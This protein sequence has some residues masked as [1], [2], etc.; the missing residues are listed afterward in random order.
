LSE[1]SSSDFESAN[2]DD[3]MTEEAAT[4]PVMAADVLTNARRFNLESMN[5]LCLIE[6]ESRLVSCLPTI[7]LSGSADSVKQFVSVALKPQSAAH[8][9]ARFVVGFRYR[10]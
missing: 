5:T 2:A 9:L 4:E 3:P 1:T 6:L 7:K 10:A 8:W